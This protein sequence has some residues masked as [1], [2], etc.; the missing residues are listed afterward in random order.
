VTSTAKDPRPE[1]SSD[2]EMILALHPDPEKQPTRCNRR[3][4][5]AYRAALLAVIPRDARGIAFRELAG[6]VKPHLDPEILAD[7]S[8]GW[9]TTTVKLDL[10]ARGL[11][12]RVPGA[13]PQRLRRTDTEDG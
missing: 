3:S 6:A 8:P 12:E 7:T 4:Y 1:E 10:E 2:R 13:R 5:E 11:V 9:W